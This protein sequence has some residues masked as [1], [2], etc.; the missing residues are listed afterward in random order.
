MET[1][2]IK[3]EWQCGLGAYRLVRM[4]DRIR[5]LV[6]DAFMI[7]P[8]R[9]VLLCAICMGPVI[10]SCTQPP[11]H[12]TMKSI[13]VSFTNIFFIPCEGGWL[14]IDVGYPGD[15]ETYL[16]EVTKI[17]INPSD[18]RYLLLTHH[19]DDHAGFAAEFVKKHDAV[20]IVHEK[21]LGPLARGAS[22]ENMRPVNG[23]VK[24]VFSVFSVFHGGFSFPPFIPR[25]K[26][27]TVTG[28]NRDILPAIGINGV[29][30]AT[31]G[32]TD[33]SISV[34]LADGTAI[35][36]D[37][38]M[39]FLGVCGIEHRPIYIK[40]IDQ[41]YAGWDRLREFGARMIYPSHGEPFAAAELVPVR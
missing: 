26:D 12:E 8:V 34:V 15:Y 37:A 5:I 31:P 29:I 40:D 23:C 25:P 9:A 10:F 33:D 17:G 16:A 6:V 36:G 18:V 22:E 32:H 30:L 11:P 35:V 3:P 1:K 38:A 7:G 21:A 39:N 14:Q 20:V 27:M 13:K 41:V 2:E 24:T 28:D 4:I 19:H